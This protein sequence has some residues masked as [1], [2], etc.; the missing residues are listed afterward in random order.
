MCQNA[1][2]SGIFGHSG[3]NMLGEGSP[4]EIFNFFH[5]PIDLMYSRKKRGIDIITFEGKVFI[6]GKNACEGPYLK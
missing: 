1:N 4:R 3:G 5:V 6:M 2:K